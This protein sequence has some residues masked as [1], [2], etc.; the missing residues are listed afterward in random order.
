MKTTKV[1][2]E[3]FLNDKAVE[4]KF[5]SYYLFLWRKTK[6]SRCFGTW[7]RTQRKQDFNKFYKLWKS[8]NGSK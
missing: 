1:I 4:D 8:Q 5:D 3:H 6:T 7:L 2:F